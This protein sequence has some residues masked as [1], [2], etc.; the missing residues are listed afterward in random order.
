MQ[1]GRK[2]E[3]YAYVNAHTG[4]LIS[5]SVADE[6]DEC[7][8]PIC[9]DPAATFGDGALTCQDSVVCA[10]PEALPNCPLCFQCIPGRKEHNVRGGICLSVCL[11]V[12]VG[13]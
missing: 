1:C 3:A 2:C 8:L 5:S 4:D 11:S 7:S 12:L 6:L 13:G 9:E 10:I